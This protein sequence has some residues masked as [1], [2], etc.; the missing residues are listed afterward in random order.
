MEA[1]LE[2]VRDSLTT[3]TSSARQERVVENERVRNGRCDG[4]GSSQVTELE[5]EH[6]DPMREEEAKEPLT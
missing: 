5:P 1:R 4:Y 2:R 3:M 6:V